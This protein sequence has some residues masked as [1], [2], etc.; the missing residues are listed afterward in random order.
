MATGKC[1][2]CFQGLVPFPPCLL[3]AQPWICNPWCGH[4]ISLLVLWKGQMDRS[5]SPRPRGLCATPAPAFRRGTG[6]AGPLR[7]RPAAVG[8]EPGPRGA[9]GLA[10][11]GKGEGLVTE[12]GGHLPVQAFSHCEP[13][14]TASVAL[15]PLPVWHLSL[16]LCG[17]FPHP[18]PWC[19]CFLRSPHH[20]SGFSLD[21][22]HLGAGPSL[23]PLAMVLVLPSGRRRIPCPRRLRG[24]AGKATL[25]IHQQVCQ[26][27]CHGSYSQLG[28]WLPRADGNNTLG[29]AGHGSSCGA[30]CG[31]AGGSLGVWPGAGREEAMSG[32]T[33]EWVTG[34]QP[35]LWLTAAFPL[36]PAIT[37][38]NT[39][40]QWH[41][42]R[43]YLLAL[44]R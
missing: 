17:P 11:H 33:A 28:W 12:H 4:G 32:E 16:C 43:S 38:A 1:S 6:T 8:G 34:M 42:G 20:C 7:S 22:P 27:D 9:A 19:C 3:G 29:P 13:S 10:E 15:R 24:T 30:C 14:A 39:R 26:R 44:A 25:P 37:L 35:H 41:L 36:T 23:T 31:S 21:T 18:S 40:I 2:L 5:P